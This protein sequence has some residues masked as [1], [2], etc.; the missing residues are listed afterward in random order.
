[1]LFN[2]TSVLF[3]PPSAQLTQTTT[4]S[5]PHP[6]LERVCVYHVR[7][8]VAS[9]SYNLLLVLVCSVYAFKTRRLPD[10][11]KESRYIALSVY[12]TL[13]IWTVFLPSYF[14]STQSYH[15][16][17]LLSLASLLNGAIAL[18]CLYIP[19]VYATLRMTEEEVSLGFRKATASGKSLSSSMLNKKQVHHDGVSGK[20]TTCASFSAI[21]MSTALVSNNAAETPAEH[22]QI[23]E[24]Q[25]SAL[26]ADGEARRAKFDIYDKEDNSE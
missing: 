12:T 17:I 16:V 5:T 2:V 3:L 22:A 24:E 21:E 23:E 11:F 14:L 9:L 18:L 15:Q 6:V 4:T 26:P 1:M 8:F 19:K 25:N 7:G 10:N 20:C 13:V